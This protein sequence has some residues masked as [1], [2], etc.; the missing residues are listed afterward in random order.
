MLLKNLLKVFVVGV[1]LNSCGKIQSEYPAPDI[2][3]GVMIW[4]GDLQ[5]SKGYFEPLFYE[6]RD[7]YE[8]QL[9]ELAK[10]RYF[11][12]S[13]KHYGELQKYI[14]TLEMVA[15]ERCK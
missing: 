6:S 12:M 7:A 1:L 13:P 4:T 5:S 2:D 14:E 11:L 3:L 8:V 10:R 9:S 15:K